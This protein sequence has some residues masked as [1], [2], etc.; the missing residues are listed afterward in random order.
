MTVET[1]K[2]FLVSDFLKISSTLSMTRGG[3]CFG[4]DRFIYDYILDT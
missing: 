4:Q 3:L 2:E 1:Q